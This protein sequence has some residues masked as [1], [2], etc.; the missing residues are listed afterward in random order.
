MFRTRLS[1]TPKFQCLSS[2]KRRAIR[3]NYVR[4]PGS[5][6]NLSRTCLSILIDFRRASAFEETRDLRDILLCEL[7]LLSLLATFQFACNIESTVRCTRLQ[8]VFGS[9]GR[10]STCRYHRCVLPILLCA[11][12]TFAPCVLCLFRSKLVREHLMTN[13]LVLP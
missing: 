13:K 6:I 4:H 2:G 5:D 11:S 3:T 10:T 1:I 7:S 8:F 12:Q 9:A